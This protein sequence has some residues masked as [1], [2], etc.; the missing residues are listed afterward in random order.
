M[1]YFDLFSS[2]Q[3][4]Y[5]RTLSPV[6]E[7]HQLTSLELSILLFLANNPGY[8]T[9]T[10]I[11]QRRRLAKSHVS[12]SIHSLERRGLLRREYRDGDRRTAHLVLEDASLP[13]VDEGK[14]AQAQFFATLSAGI[15]A[16][17]MNGLLECLRLMGSNVTSALEEVQA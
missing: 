7:R 13:A 16:E 11:V 2:M 9:A 1:D 5:Q 3:K 17:Q 8:D 10:S 15:P 14:A 4:L 6:C 12:T